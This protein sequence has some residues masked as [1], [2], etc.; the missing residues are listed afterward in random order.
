MSAVGSGGLLLFLWEIT[1]FEPPSPAAPNMPQLLLLLLLLLPGGASGDSSASGSACD[2]T[3]LAGNE[4]VSSWWRSST[5]TKSDPYV[6]IFTAQNATHF[7]VTS[8]SSK[9]GW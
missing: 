8:K 9:P 6:Y 4:W 3:K 7:S 2:A 5:P 1:K